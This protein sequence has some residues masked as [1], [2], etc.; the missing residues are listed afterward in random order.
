[1]KQRAAES[2]SLT[3]SQLG[4]IDGTPELDLP[5]PATHLH[6]APLLLTS[7]IMHALSRLAAR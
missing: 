2:R 1:M 5:D 6:T 4:A 3:F 7:I